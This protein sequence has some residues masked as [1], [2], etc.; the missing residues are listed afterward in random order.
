[1]G[2]GMGQY[3]YEV[4]FAGRVFLS[5]MGRALRHRDLFRRTA[6][7]GNRVANSMCPESMTPPESGV[8]SGD[9]AVN[10]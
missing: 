5:R 1:M 6:S 10:I 9:Q 3:F 2:L 8:T 7:L 4:G